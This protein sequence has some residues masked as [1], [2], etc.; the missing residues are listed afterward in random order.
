MKQKVKHF[1]GVVFALAMCVCMITP[2]HSLAEG[3][4]LSPWE[5]LCEMVKQGGEIVLTQDYEAN[6]RDSAL[7]IPEGG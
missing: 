6:S 4:D 5:E 2:I 7:E 1:L 3:E